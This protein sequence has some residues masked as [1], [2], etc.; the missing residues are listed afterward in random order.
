MYSK[1]LVC[2]SPYWSSY[3]ENKPLTMLSRWSLTLNVVGNNYKKQ[4]KTHVKYQYY[5][6]VN[7]VPFR[8]VP[9]LPVKK[10]WQHLLVHEWFVYFI[11]NC[12][13]YYFNSV[14]V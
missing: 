6:H 2:I 4:N 5:F 3:L 7:E 14:F 13:M 10:Q 12:I 11:F 9:A 8:H 1:D